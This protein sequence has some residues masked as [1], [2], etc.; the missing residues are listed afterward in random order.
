MGGEGMN[1]E[2]AKTL[3]IILLLV[4]NLV[5]GGI[6]LS[7]EW[8]ER[9]VERHAMEDLCSILGRNGLLAKP[10]QISRDLALTFDVERDIYERYPQPGQPSVRGLYV[11]GRVTGSWLW[12]DA[13][14]IG[15]TLSISAG[16]ALLQMTNGWGKTGVLDL[17]ELGF[18]ASPVAP[19]VL[20]LHPCWR[21]VISGEEFFCHGVF[22]RHS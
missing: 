3:L 6:L 16:H 19:D 1:W 8:H 12:N 14:P 10:E 5:L 11:W 2:R 9:A 18:Y 13:L 7:R 21:F 17:A 15:D 4:V 22:T 20:R